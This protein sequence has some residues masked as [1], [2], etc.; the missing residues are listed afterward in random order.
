MKVNTIFCFFPHC[1]CGGG[2]NCADSAGTLDN[3]NDSYCC[4]F[5][6]IPLPIE[7]CGRRVHS[8]M[9]PALKWTISAVLFLMLE[10]S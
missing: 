4:Q 7:N 5:P 10:L 3:A 6:G 2:C 1:V 9:L 8:L